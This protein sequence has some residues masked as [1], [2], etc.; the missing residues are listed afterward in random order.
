M[1][2]ELSAEIKKI[3]SWITKN[4]AIDVIL[5]GSTMRG[6]S[7]PRDIDICIIIK[8]SFE[9]K[10]I[11]LVD[12]LGKLLD[13]S[14]LKF[15]ISIMTASAFVKGDTL[16]KTLLTEGYS[17]LRNLSFSYN[18][19][20]E[21]KS[22]FIYNLNNFTQSERVQLHYLMKGRYGSKGILK[23]IGGKFIGKGAILVSTEKE[24]ILKEVFE[25]WEIDYKIERMLRG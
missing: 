11:D 15:Q 9:E 14:S 21:S 25:K 2:K 4:K 17:I 5:F 8:D 13:S 20:F 7:M 24:D 1:Q 6:K 3:K 23:E 19:G 22:M 16:A 10:S 18:F 12:S